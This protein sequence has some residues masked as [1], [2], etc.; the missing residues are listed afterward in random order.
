[1][2]DWLR[3][4]RAER[5]EVK[6]FEAERAEKRGEHA[7]ARTLYREA[8]EAFAPLALSVPASN[9]KTRTVLGV[10]AV[11]TYARAG[12]FG[13]A[14]D[15]GA[16]LLAEDAALTPEGKIEILRLVEEYQGLMR[17][18]SAK[19]ESAHA[20]SRTAAARDGVLTA[21]RS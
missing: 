8:A 21:V 17:L 10:A 19:P 12:S 6:T 15:V 5:G 2:T 18:V 1:M 9:P 20:A 14:V 7:E 4:P 13:L 3:D 16:R 11:V